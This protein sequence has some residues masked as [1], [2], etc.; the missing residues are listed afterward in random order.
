MSSSGMIERT[1]SDIIDTE[2]KEY[3]MYVLENR[4][5][6]SYIDGQ[7]PSGRKILYSMINQF[8]G[9]KVKVAE[10]GSSLPSYGYHHGEASAM[11]AAITLTADWNNNIPIF[12]GYG[13]FGSRLVQNSAAPRYIFCD[14]NPEFSK[15]FYDDSVCTSRNDP[16]HPEPQQYLPIIPWVLVNGIEG[17]AVGFACRYLPHSP[18]DIAKACIKAVKGKLKEDHV[19][20]V[21]FPYFKGTI[22]QEE[23]NKIISRGVV[24]RVKRNT[25]LITEVPWG[26]DREK[27]FINLD[28]MMEQNKIQDFEDQCDDSGFKFQVKMDGNQD[29]KCSSD[30]IAYFKLE[31]SYSENYTALDENGK[32]ILFNNKNEIIK[33]FVEFRIGKIQERIDFDIQKLNN[34][35][36]WYNK[37]SEFVSD[38]VS[39]KINLIGYTKKKLLEYCMETYSVEQDIASRM[40]G[41]PIYDMTSDVIEE[42]N[43]KISRTKLQI[44]NLKVSDPKEVY[45]EMLQKIA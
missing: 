15:Y 19:L 8:K 45:L 1:V 34:D 6:P 33:K 26:Y 7:K 35:L 23:T 9:K 41:T 40:I 18:K 25:W 14:L 42:L 36:Y 31:R 16:E 32:L 24:E 20:P 13:N 12:R 29:A 11:G 22:I 17:I 30:P 43:E 4:A 21:T 37:K 5:I 39:K 10:L 27:F 28:K 38:V 3:A 2:Y 44:D